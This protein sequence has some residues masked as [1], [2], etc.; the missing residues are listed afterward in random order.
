MSHLSDMTAVDGGDCH[1]D[2]AANGLYTKMLNFALYS[3]GKHNDDD[4]DGRFEK[5][6]PE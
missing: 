3:G 5:A 1:N 2:R 4:D 6:A